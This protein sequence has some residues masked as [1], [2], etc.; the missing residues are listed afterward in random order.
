MLMAE[1]K[2]DG[3]E[4]RLALSRSC[5]LQLPVASYR[6]YSTVRNADRLAPRKPPPLGRGRGELWKKTVFLPYREAPPFRVGKASLFL[7]TLANPAAS[8]GEYARFFGSEI[9]DATTFERY[10]V[11]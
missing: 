2:L 6:E 1:C 5:L 3:E 11:L 7:D 10:L 4:K 9:H 8:Y